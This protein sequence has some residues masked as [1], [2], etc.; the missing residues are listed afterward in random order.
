[1]S[2][3]AYT[4]GLILAL[5]LIAAGQVW[6]R[7]ISVHSAADV[8]KTWLAGD[9]LV[10]TNGTYNGK[11]I[12][13]KGTG[14]ATAPIVLQAQTTGQVNLT[15][16]SRLTIDGT[17]IEVK[18]F[19]FSGTNTG[20]DHVVQ[21][22]SA[23]SNCRL[24]DCNIDSFNPTDATK[25]FKW[26]SLKGQQNRVDH[27]SFVNKTNIGTLLVVWLETGVTPLH[28]IDHN[29]F[30]YR[31]A[32]LDSNGKELNGQEIIRIGDSSTS[33][34]T[35]ACTIEDNTF[36]NC[37]GEIET[38]SNKSCGNIY[39]HNTFLSCAGTLTLRHGNNCTVDAN[40]FLGNGKTATGGVRII[41]EGHI[42]TNNY[43]EQLNGN[44]YRAAICIVRGKDNSALNEYY[45]VKDVEISNNTF[46]NC[47]EAFCIN[48]N[49]SSECNMAP[50]ATTIE[51]NI[52]Y[53][54][55]SNRIVTVAQTGGT[56]AWLN[57]R[58]NTGTWKNYS[59]ATPAWISVPDMQQPENSNPELAT[60][61]IPSSTMPQT[62]KYLRN[63][64]LYLIYEGLIYNIQGQLYNQ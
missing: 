42:V 37:D 43:F 19:T 20:T 57:N 3:H 34:Q 52:V 63:G 33:M 45:Q 13:I 44:N 16:K 55:S 41:G 12:T 25:D 64:Q 58:Y 32:N 35:A 51:N 14:T 48:Y 8:N 61:N 22:T 60:E 59:P 17:Y 40:T 54:E 46:V 50:L 28:R 49:S 5:L 1:M 26:V 29:Y 53:N 31:I 27:C 56:I 47:K 30:G 11:V 18:G 21:F 7:V 4:Y 24:T 39:R 23:S 36:D 9:T 2:R 38:I 62:H 10:W 6:G 15:T